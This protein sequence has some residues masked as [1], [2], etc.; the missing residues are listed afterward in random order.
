LFGSNQGVMKISSGAGTPTLVTL[1]DSSRRE[2]GHFFPQFL[3]DGRH[4]LYMRPA[5]ANEQS[6]LFA[7]SIDL[8]PDQQPKEQILE[9]IFA[10]YVQSANG[11]GHIFFLRGDSIFVQPFDA[12]SLQLSGQPVLVIEHA[13]ALAGLT[14]AENGVLAYN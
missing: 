4:F 2:G 11:D 7:G 14:A 9:N 8:K 5:A 6:G 1:R 3:P 10:R 13:N 12:R